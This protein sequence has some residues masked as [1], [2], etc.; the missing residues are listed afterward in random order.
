MEAVVWPI[1]SHSLPF[2]SFIFTCKCSLPRVISLAQGLWFLLHHHWWALTGTPLGHPAVLCHGILM[3]RICRFVPHMFQHFIDLGVVGVGQ[4]I[5]L[6]LGLGA[7]ELTQRAW[8]QERLPHPPPFL[9]HYPLQQGRKLA[10]RGYKSGRTSPA[11]HVLKCKKECFCFLFY[12]STWSGQHTRAN[13][14][15]VGRGTGGP[16]LR[17]WEQ[18]SCTPPPWAPY[19]SRERALYL[20]W[21]K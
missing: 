20:A 15:V 5:A 13:P 18:E 21:T 2:S 1:E 10:P 16:A 9:T 12:F 11:P 4:L 6:A 19:S 17:A 3:F 8:E 7:G 14:V